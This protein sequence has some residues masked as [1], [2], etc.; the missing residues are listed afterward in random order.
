MQTISDNMR[1]ALYMMLAMAGYVLNDAMMKLAAPDIGL[2]QAIFVRGLM[3]SSI[4]AAIAWRRGVFSAYRSSFSPAL[5]TRIS[6]EV[7]AGLFFLFALI[8]MPI[9]NVT[10]ILQV[11]PLAVTLAAAWFLGEPVG[12]RRYLAIS[13]GFVGVLIIVRPGSEGFSTY[14]IMALISVALIVLRDLATR[15]LPANV[16]SVLVGF[17]TSLAVTITAFGVVIF[18]PWQ[19]IS[20]YEMLI[21]VAASIFLVVGT[22]FIVMTM[23]VG[24]ISFV[25]PFRYT[26]IIWAIFLGI[27]IFGEYPDTYTIVG[28]SI[29]I[30][31]GIYS[32]YRERT[33][34]RK[35]V[36]AANTKP[37]NR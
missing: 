3:V 35:T 7:I 33:I 8:N 13:V 17:Y 23:R 19:P 6:A 36:T 31:M 2:F 10:A 22:L 37:Q 26:M 30:I 24:E 15:K 28:S 29:V 14:S 27:V 16:A 4:L 11:L 21:L 18:L 34:A 5:F 1:G 32:F 20:A 25:S 9:A 12:W